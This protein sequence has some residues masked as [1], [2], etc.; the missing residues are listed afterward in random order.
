MQA[1]RRNVDFGCCFKDDSEDAKKTNS[2]RDYG[3]CSYFDDDY[4][5]LFLETEHFANY[6]DYYFSYAWHLGICL[7]IG[8]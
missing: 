8:T 3:L 2:D 4:Q 1:G 5:H 6:A 7:I